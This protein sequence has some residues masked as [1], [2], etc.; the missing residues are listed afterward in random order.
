MSDFYRFL[1]V[2]NAA[3][4]KSNIYPKLSQNR[5]FSRFKPE[6]EKVTFW[7]FYEVVLPDFF[8]RT[9]EWIF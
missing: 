4:K 9:K 5:K 6:F 7:T 2:K 8:R 1:A 3:K